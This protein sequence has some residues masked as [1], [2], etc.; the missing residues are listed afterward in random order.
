MTF[1]LLAVGDVVGD[2]GIEMLSRHLP[3]LKR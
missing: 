3:A 1:N 2:S